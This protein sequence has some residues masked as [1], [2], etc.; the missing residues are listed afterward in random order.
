MAAP[1]SATSSM[2]RT[3]R[4]FLFGGIAAATGLVTQA[5]RSDPAL[6]A[7]D[8]PVILGNENHAER[9]TEVKG[10]GNNTFA[11]IGEATG[12]TG[13]GV[14]VMGMSRADEGTGLW[15]VATQPTGSNQGVLARSHSSAGTG[16]FAHASAPSGPAI[17]VDARADS[18]EGIASPCAQSAHRPARHRTQG[19][20]QRT[21]LDGRDR[22]RPEGRRPSLRRDGAPAHEC[23][24]DPLHAPVRSGREDLP[25]TRREERNQRPL[26]DRPD[27]GCDGADQGRMVR[28]RLGCGLVGDWRDDEH[29]VRTRSPRC[30]NDQ[31]A[32]G[33][34]SSFL[35]PVAT[36]SVRLR[37]PAP[38]R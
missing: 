13:L 16:L 33:S 22:D 12:V 25:T 20:G 30:P 8:D 26:H 11:F 24:E 36:T 35:I 7:D 19:R 17:A 34:A 6:A 21:L 3:R 38:L 10:D 14:G 31:A 2:L 15:G 23:I 1:D 32:G 29:R 27:G 37:A 9:V 4:A 18:P 5:I 28:D